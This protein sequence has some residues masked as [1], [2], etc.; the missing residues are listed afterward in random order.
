[1]KLIAFLCVVAATF[2]FPAS[3]ARGPT[4][5]PVEIVVAVPA[6]AITTITSE[7]AVTSAHGFLL[8]INAWFERDI[9]QVFDYDIQIQTMPALEFAGRDA[10][11]S[12]AGYGVM[13]WVDSYLKVP[14]SKGSRVMVLLVG[15]GGW[16]G[17]FA[18]TDKG[19]GVYH[20]GMAGDWGVMQDFGVPT[21]CVPTGDDANRGFSHEFAGMMGMY[22]GGG[23]YG[24]GMGCFAGDAMSAVE[25]SALLKYSGSWLRDP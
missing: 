3:A 24:D 25:K 19:N 7:Q 21:A 17:H 13:A 9:G 12:Y 22:I 11:G 8:E 16:A 6:D 14:V 5:K 10:C 1:M 4:S 2:A 20:F 15:G 23:C 18:P